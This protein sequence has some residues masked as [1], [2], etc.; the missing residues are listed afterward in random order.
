MLR[1]RVRAP[2]GEAADSVLFTMSPSLRLC[3]GSVLI[4]CPPCGARA[5]ASSIAQ[6]AALA[7]L[8]LGPGG[9]APVAEMAAA[10]RER[11]DFLFASLTAIPGV[12][13]E[14]AARPA[15][16]T[17]YHDWCIVCRIYTWKPRLPWHRDI[18][19]PVGDLP[20]RTV[21]GRAWGE[22]R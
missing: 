5:G 17:I 19:G 2:G 15:S 9:G 6:H 11:R 22:P 10:F 7:A 13:L 3:V 4:G 1:P 21:V 14:V 16:K 20:G 18:D 8:A 12:K